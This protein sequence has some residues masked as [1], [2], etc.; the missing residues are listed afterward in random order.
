M[1]GL[2]VYNAKSKASHRGWLWNTIAKRISKP[3]RDCLGCVL[4]G[5]DN[6]DVKKATSVGFVIPNIIAVDVIPDRIKSHR[7]LGGIGIVG[8]IRSVLRHWNDRPLDFLVLDTC[9][10]YYSCCSMYLEGNL[11]GAIDPFTTVYVNMQR[12]REY[13]PSTHNIS[14]EDMVRAFGKHRGRWFA[15]WI[16]GDIVAAMYGDGWIKSHGYEAVQMCNMIVSDGLKAEYGSYKSRSVRMDSI[17]FEGG[18]RLE[19]YL[20]THRPSERPRMDIDVERRM[21]A[22]KAV[23]TKALRGI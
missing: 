13:P 7:D 21:P 1:I 15:N 20:H 22:L 16:A 5:P 11:S 2:P 4:I 14:V 3:A 18:P 6:S 19:K 10:T 12:G 23:R 17:I 8:D 9:S